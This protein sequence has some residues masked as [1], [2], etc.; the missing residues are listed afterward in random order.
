MTK[1][2][3]DSKFGGPAA[4]AI[5]P[6]AQALYSK[7]GVRIVGI[8]E[9]AHTSRTEPAPEEDAEPQVTLAIKHL[10]I[11][12]PGEHD[13]WVRKAMAALYLQ[14]TAQGKLGEE[15]EVELSE[16]T[17]AQTAGI[18]QGVEVARLRTTVSHWGEYAARCGRMEDVT[19]AQLQNELQTVGQALQAALRLVSD[20]DDD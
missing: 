14:R 8:V 4:A 6:L 1:V 15:F 16:R 13:E 17:L 7:R 9:L 20:G 3:L 5:E 19:I 18:L 11:A 12:R 2:K 10:E